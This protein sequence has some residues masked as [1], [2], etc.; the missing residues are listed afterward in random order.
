VA[1]LLFALAVAAVTAGKSLGK[2][3]DLSDHYLEI[4][5]S[6]NRN[7]ASHLWTS[8]VLDKA[9][10]M[11]SSK[12]LNIFKG[13][14]AVSGSPLPDDPRTMYKVTLPRVGGG[15]ATGVVRHCCWPCICDLSDLVRVD[16]KTVVTADGRRKLDFLVMGDPCKHPEKL[17][18]EFTD[19]FTMMK[20]K[21]NQEAPEVACKDGRLT[22]AVLSD[23]GHPIIGMF[24]TSAHDLQAVPEPPL[25]KKF[26]NAKDPTFGF[27]GMCVMRQKMGY[28]S[29]MGLIFHLVAGIAPI[30]GTPSLPFPP[31]PKDLESEIMEKAAVVPMVEVPRLPGSR[32]PLLLPLVASV[33]LAALALLAICIRGRASKTQEA[34]RDPEDSDRGSSAVE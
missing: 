3:E 18:D 10:G 31:V 32:S 30:P 5:K 14:C 19:P 2:P 26:S 25:P 28:N 1:A 12:L 6:G 15:N 7:A 17:E 9:E 33:F 29:G 20:V 16:S 23:S 22:G 24:F 21:L 34:G 11:S 13:F 4:F 8:F 27:G